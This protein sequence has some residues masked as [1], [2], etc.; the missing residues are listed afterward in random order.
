MLAAGLLSW[1][2]HQ[3]PPISIPS[4]S[5]S[6]GSKPSHAFSSFTPVSSFMESFSKRE[7]EVDEGRE[8]TLRSDIKPREQMM[9][10]HGGA[11]RI[12]R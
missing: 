2:N 8:R 3:L 11:N 5:C 7:E 1:V 4:V 9:S 12:L 6:P 10:R